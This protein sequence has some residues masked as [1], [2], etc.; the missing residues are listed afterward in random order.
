MLA[1]F[2]LIVLVGV[3]RTI[4]PL[5]GS[6]SAGLLIIMTT[7][8]FMVYEALML[9]L[10]AK[11]MAV[12]RPLS[13]SLRRLSSVLECVFPVCLMA[14][15]IIMTAVNPYTILV[16]PGYAI[17]MIVIAL[18][19]LQLDPSQ[20]VTTG[21][22]GTL[23][24]LALVIFVLLG[25]D[26]PSPHPTAMYFTLTL[27]LAVATAAITF[28]TIQVRHYVI[29]AVR[30]VETR[31]QHDQMRR[32]LELARDI[33]RGL[34]PDTTPS[35]PGYDFAAMSRAA[36]LAGGDYY[37]WQLVREGR[38]VISIADVTGHGV[39]PAL[40]TAACRAYMRAVMG[41]K[42]TL[43]DIV[44]RVNRL[45]H[46]DLSTGRFVTF[47][48]IDIDSSTH[49]GVFLSAG[50]GPTMW[51]NGNDGSV[52]S[53]DSQGLPFGIV[54]EQDWDEAYLVAFGLDDIVVL[55]SDGFFES[56]NS[57]GTQFG[58]KR[59]QELVRAHRHESAQAILQR[60]DDEVVGWI[61]EQPQQDDMTA[62]V[63]KRIK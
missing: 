30:E 10:A 41:D 59:L 20:S 16:S 33:Q 60:M 51:L 58:L 50:H 6:E 40:V 48:L 57:D 49:E 3:F 45:L 39:G 15:L 35:L 24:Y 63:I 47:A 42:H 7:I 2:G 32:D 25:T 37:D 46:E 12:A 52:K 21:V 61:G 56:A 17:I 38:L 28:V 55:F 53:I 31:R 1:A 23:G 4:V 44:A 54:A 8:P 19:P 62:V 13:P 14:T 11:R 43:E 18:A 9:R 34:L 27:M 36:E 22:T 29:G 5:A 26:E